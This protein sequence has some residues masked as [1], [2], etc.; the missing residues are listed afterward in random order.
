MLK[1]VLD[2]SFSKNTAGTTFANLETKGPKG[3]IGF[4]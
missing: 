4:N 1:E 2:F 3:D